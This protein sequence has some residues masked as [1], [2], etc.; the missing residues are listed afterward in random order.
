[1][2]GVR[3]SPWTGAVVLLTLLAASLRVWQLDAVPPGWRDDELSNVF[4]L[5]AQVLAGE[6]RLYYV[7]ASGQE[8]LYYLLSAATETLFGRT[9]L[10]IRGVSVFFGVLTIPLTYLVGRLLLDR[11]AGFLAAAM[12]TL[13]FWSLMYSRIG[14]RQILMPAFWLATVA[15]LWYGL[16]RAEGVRA[17][18]YLALAGFWL[19]AGFYTYFAARG[20]PLIVAAWLG[21]LA[22]S[23]PSRL[24]ARWR[25]VA[26]L[27][28]VAL[29]TTLPL[30]LTLRQL[31][32]A[33]ARIAEVAKPLAA[34]QAGNYAPLREH[35]VRTLSMFH[36]DGDDE[37]LYNIPF[38]PVFNLPGA[39]WLWLGVGLATVGMVVGLRHGGQSGVG[40]YAPAAWALLLIWWGAGLAPAFV[41]VP[42]ASLGHTIAAQPATYLLAAAPIAGLT[43]RRRWLGAAL[44]GLALVNVAARDLPDYF[45][46]W[47]AGGNTRF[48]YRADIAEVADYLAA[49]PQLTD[50]GITGL[51]A[52]PWD[53]LALELDAPPHASRPRWFNAERALLLAVAGRPALNFQGYPQTTTLFDAAYAPSPAA[54][55]GAY[56][57]KQVN[58][59]W[60]EP[61][62][63]CFTNGL[64]LVDV[65]YQPEG[66]VDVTLRVAH[67]LDLP[68]LPIVSFPPPPGVYVGPRLAVFA[69]LWD[70]AG[71]YLTGDDG[72]WV[73]PVTLH[74]GDVFR[75]RHYLSPPAGTVAQTLAI[76]LYDPLTG[77]RIL[78]LQGE[79]HVPLSPAGPATSLPLP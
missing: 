79:D 49:D 48:L 50:F 17:G 77:Q 44:A 36:S 5:T 41:S 38:R 47:P 26:L 39:A 19:G 31:P 18:R 71:G 55:A 53:R 34:A 10:G 45:V 37:D 3:L 8:G 64:C 2:R 9:P 56:S 33:D 11:R 13:S 69:H 25:G 72:L 62:Q 52:G 61:F 57:L 24:R 35:L 23:D 58:E 63:T 30:W 43:R 76:G 59:V 14:L 4:A 28:G 42:P 65:V 21:Y 15:S 68:P 29:V 22:W 54:T 67:P 70:A 7:D 12:L 40:G 27:V 51:L 66:T 73:D 78:T 60:S 75:Q 1:M 46:V 74:T 6:P 32:A 16:Y 20:A